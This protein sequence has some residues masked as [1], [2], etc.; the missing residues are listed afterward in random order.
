MLQCAGYGSVYREVCATD[1]VVVIKVEHQSAILE[2]PMAAGITQVQ[3]IS[4]ETSFKE[5]TAGQGHGAR[6][7]LAGFTGVWYTKRGV[8]ER[9]CENL[10]QVHLD[11]S[12]YKWLH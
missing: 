4:R 5:L 3:D 10:K 7:A 11:I 1:M 8:K 12:A 9:R 2:R 6:A